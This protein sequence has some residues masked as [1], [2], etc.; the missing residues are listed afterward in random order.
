MCSQSQKQSKIPARKDVFWKSPFPF[1]FLLKIRSWNLLICNEGCI[2]CFYE[3]LIVI[4]NACMYPS[5][6][7]P[8]IFGIGQIAW[9]SEAGHLAPLIMPGS[10]TVGN[11]DRL[12]RQKHREWRGRKTQVNLGL[13]VSGD[14]REVI[15]GRRQSWKHCVPIFRQSFI[16]NSCHKNDRRALSSKTLSGLWIIIHALIRKASAATCLLRTPPGKSTYLTRYKWSRI[17]II[18]V[19]IALA[20]NF[21]ETFPCPYQPLPSIQFPYLNDL[22]L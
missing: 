8:H 12:G 13:G 3:S 20:Q 2:D 16:M 4:A 7:Q 5:P 18:S 11:G 19:K 14:G 1:S 22:H 6:M 9:T 10:P 17:V 15:S 21:N